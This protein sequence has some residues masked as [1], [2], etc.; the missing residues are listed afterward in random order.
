[1]K[2]ISNN[3]FITELSKL[4]GN[5][6]D[7]VTEIPH[8]VAGVYAFF[9]HYQFPSSGTNSPQEAV[10]Y[11]ISQIEQPH[12][13]TRNAHVSPLFRV[14]I[15][16][17]R[18]LSKNKTKNLGKAISKSSQRGVFE[19]V[20]QNSFLFQTPLYVGKSINIRRRIVEHL[21]G[22]T[23]LKS[24]LFEAGIEIKSCS[25]M[26]IITDENPS[27]ENITEIS[28]EAELIEDCLSRLFCPGFTR[29]YG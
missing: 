19:E 18:S 22:D 28:N 3:I 29:R 8:D 2:R 23:N 17:E 14:S 9:K 6:D 27:F 13:L 7:L 12:M 21:N 11:L 5:C 10:D 26:F 1:V 25:I 24:D 4:S 16:S 20:F 15:S